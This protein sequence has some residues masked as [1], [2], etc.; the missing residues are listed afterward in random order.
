MNAPQISVIIPAYNAG[1][2][3]KE[4]INSVI[5][6]TFQDW[7]LIIVNDGSTDDTAQ[8]A[9][10][11]VD[12]RIRVVEQQNAGVSAARNTGIDTARGSHITFLDADDAMHPNN[13]AL[14]MEALKG[15]GADWVFGDITLCD[16]SLQ[17]TGEFLRGTSGDILRTL[18]LQEEPAVPLSCGNIVAKM[19]CFDQGVRFD[20][21]LSNAADQDF[22]MQ[23]AH[24]F[25][26]IHVPEALTLY[27]DVPGSMSKDIQRY[28]EDHLR[29]FQKAEERELL[30]PK[31]FRNRC[32]AN[33]YWAIGGSWWLLARRKS[34]GMWWFLRAFFLYPP[35]ITR[36]I[37]KRIA[38]LAKQPG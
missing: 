9:R 10:N 3:L 28:Q 4:A 21:E 27:R 30:K 31:G 8:V 11:H 19:R 14:K 26:G 32:W 33:V 5:Q 22:T 2:W 6:Q 7:E 37:S 16:A 29:L 17:P 12:T 34:K 1:A 38:M 13:L 18:L 20:E 24:R 23:L 36:P 15:S 35:V 25:K